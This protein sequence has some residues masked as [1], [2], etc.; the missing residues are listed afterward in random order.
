M[1]DYCSRP[2]FSGGK[3]AALRLPRMPISGEAA[4]LAKS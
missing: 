3:D 2:E 4:S 1:L